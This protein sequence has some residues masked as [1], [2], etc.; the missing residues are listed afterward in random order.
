LVLASQAVFTVQDLAATWPK[1]VT[2][3]HPTVR[4][5]TL[6]TESL[7]TMALAGTTFHLSPPP[8]IR[9]DTGFTNVTEESF[10]GA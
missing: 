5:M 2:S 1:V 3:L 6:A 10:C 4:K 7:W 8:D 9:H